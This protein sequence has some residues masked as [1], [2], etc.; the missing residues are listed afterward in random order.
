MKKDARGHSNMA[1]PANRLEPDS[2]AYR[3]ENRNALDQA[4]S[5]VSGSLENGPKF[6]A[7][8]SNNAAKFFVTRG[9]SRSSPS[10]TNWYRSFSYGPGAGQVASRRATNTTCLA[11]AR[12]QPVSGTPARPS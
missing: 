9:T 10:S 3:S 8:M 2:E 11:P 6:H 12:C 4:A 1:R 5:M 7:N